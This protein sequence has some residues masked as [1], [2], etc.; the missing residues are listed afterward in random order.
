MQEPFFPD[1]NQEG[2]DRSLVGVFL[3]ALAL[4]VLLTIFIYYSGLWQAAGKLLMGVLG[5]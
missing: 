5:G 4:M 2:D 1:P 3:I